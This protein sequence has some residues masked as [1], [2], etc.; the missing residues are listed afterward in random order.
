VRNL[1]LPIAIIVAIGGCILAVVAN[2]TTNN[3]HEDLGREQYHRMEAER[4]LQQAERKI[5]A[6][7]KEVEEASDKIQSIQTILSRGKTEANDLQSK[8]DVVAQEKKS[9]ADKIR[10]LEGE[11]PAPVSSHN[12]EIFGNP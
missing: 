2:I 1:S 9:L 3:I 11:L 4:S 6:L 10:E 7:T 12:A 5:A 8:L